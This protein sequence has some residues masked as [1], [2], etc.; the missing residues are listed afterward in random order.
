MRVKEQDIRACSGCGTVNE[1]E[2]FGF[3][4]ET[5]ADACHGEEKLQ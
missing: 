2:G 1:L 3:W 5:M 4:S